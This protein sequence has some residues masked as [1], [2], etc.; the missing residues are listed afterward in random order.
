M[1]RLERISRRDSYAPPGR[2][3]LHDVSF[4]VE[5]GEV[6]C[7][8]GER[9]SG[10]S[11]LLRI[12]AGLERPDEGVVQIGTRGGGEGM[13]VGYVQRRL[14]DEMGTVLEQVASPLLARRVPWTNARRRALQALNGIGL[15]ECAALYPS[16][17]RAAEVMLVA[18]A[19]AVIADPLVLVADEPTDG[20]DQIE[21]EMIERRLEEIARDGTAVLMCGGRLRFA[22]RR[23][24]LLNGTISEPAV[25]VAPV[26]PFPRRAATNGH[27]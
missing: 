20:V 14:N 15:A 2:M 27:S 9:K 25:H 1:L 18:I 22:G 26:I 4:T 7:V 21:A 13:W 8:M 16:E 3:L 19:K 10:K 6:V 12:A 23:L 24:I 11:T 5:V 17:L